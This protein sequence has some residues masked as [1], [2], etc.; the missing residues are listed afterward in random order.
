MARGKDAHQAKKDALNA[1]G[2]DLSRRA[3]SACELC[4]ARDGCRP[5][6]LADAADP[7]E[8]G[9]AVLLCQR[10]KEALTAKRLPGDTADYR[11]LEGVAWSEVPPVQI[12]AVRLLRRLDADWAS[13]TLDG[14]WLSDEIAARLE[15]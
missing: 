5:M 15:A 7:P 6:A 13:E 4:E 1:L 3:G 9:D 2:K 14:L 8:L 10:C 12:T 11:F